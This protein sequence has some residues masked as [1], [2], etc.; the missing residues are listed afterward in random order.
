MY[1]VITV[2][3]P[4][5]ANEEVVRVVVISV[6]LNLTSSDTSNGDTVH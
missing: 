6:Q 1:P 4:A 3:A 2:N 5:N